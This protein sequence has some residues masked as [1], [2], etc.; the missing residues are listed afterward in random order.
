MIAAGDTLGTIAKKNGVSVKAIEEANPGIDAKKLQIGHKLQIPASAAVATAEAPKA[1]GE[2]AAAASGD[3]TIYV[4]KSGDNLV[5]IA[6]A[7]DTSVKAHRGAQRHE[8]LRH[9]GRSKTESAGDESGFGGRGA[10]SGRHDGGPG[11]R[12]GARHAGADGQ[13]ELV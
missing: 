8:D 3:A 10:R 12:A 11:P 6:K 1:G 13:G 2:A 9:Q 4:V 5:K 7:H